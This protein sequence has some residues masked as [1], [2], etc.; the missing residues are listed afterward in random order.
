MHQPENLQRSDSLRQALSGTPSQ[1]L[2]IVQVMHLWSDLQY[3]QECLQTHRQLLHNMLRMLQVAWLSGGDHTL[4]LVG[5][6]LLQLLDPEH[7][8]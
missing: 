2:E 1:N 8:V 7:H 5:P 3:I 4:H 6:A